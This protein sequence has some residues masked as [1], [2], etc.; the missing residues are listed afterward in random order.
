M[1]TYAQRSD[2]GFTLGQ[3]NWRFANST[4]AL[5]EHYFITD[6][7]Y[8]VLLSNLKNTEKKSALLQFQGESFGGCC[9]GMSATAVLAYYGLIDYEYYC[10]DTDVAVPTCLYDLTADGENPTPEIISLINYYQASQC[11]DVSRQYAVRMVYKMTEAERLQ[12]LIDSLKDGT[13]QVLTFWGNLSNVTATPYWGG[14]AVVAYGVEYGN[15]RVNGKN[16]DGRVLIYNNAAPMDALVNQNAFYF[17]TSDWSWYNQLYKVGSEEGG[18]LVHIA[19]D[20]VLLNSG[21]MLSG[22][23]AYE[24]E[25]PFID[26]MVTTELLSEHSLQKIDYEDGIWNKNDDSMD[27]CKQTR[28]FYVEET[29]E[30]DQ[31][32]LLPGEE[33]GYVLEMAQPQPMKVAMYYE[34]SIQYV[35]SSNSMQYVV[36][37]SGFAAMTGENAEYELEMVFNERCYQGNWYDFTVSG[38][39]DTASLQKMEDGWI[40]KSDNLQ[41]VTATAGND[42]IEATLTFSTDADSV[43]LCEVNKTTLAAKIDTDGD[44]T[45]ET[46]LSSNRSVSLG[47][48]NTD[49]SVDAFDAAKILSA[50]ATVGLGAE[51][52]L[53]AEQESAADVNNDG[54][55][56]ATDAAKVLEYAAYAGSGGELEF[57]EYLSQ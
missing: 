50:A 7:D 41:N 40:L 37:P 35:R 14:H 22:T 9:Y 19:S 49:G 29:A 36:D 24:T 26:V 38:T 11:M 3:N 23:P 12:Y 53:T 4:T 2:D 27:A 17:N 45:Y 5:G 46:K 6:E 42:V 13:P 15:Y 43:L 30:S 51:S 32:F 18:M 33:S 25:E 1:T 16:Y 39:A 47:D 55:F 56:D 52:G 57:E 8:A 20:P 31:S 10:S 48:I 54:V 34:D 44:G 28:A 21:G